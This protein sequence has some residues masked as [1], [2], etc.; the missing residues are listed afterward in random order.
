MYEMSSMGRV[1]NEAGG[2]SILTRGMIGGGR[3]QWTEAA[4][5]D[6]HAWARIFFLFV[7]SADK[8]SHVP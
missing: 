1:V 3:G 7:N 2:L 6:A 5:R 4:E 8:T